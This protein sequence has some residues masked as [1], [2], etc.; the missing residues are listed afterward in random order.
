MLIISPLRWCD[1]CQWWARMDRQEGQNSYQCL[2]CDLRSRHLPFPHEAKQYQELES[3][4]LS[5]RPLEDHKKES[6]FVIMLG[7][8][9]DRLSFKQQAVLAKYIAGQIG[10]SLDLAIGRFLTGIEIMTLP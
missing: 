5:G 7:L 2:D 9:N 10:Y 6:I 8:W 1:A 3:H 4:L